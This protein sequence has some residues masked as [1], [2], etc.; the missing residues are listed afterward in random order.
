[1]NKKPITFK[2]DSSF[3]ELIKSA[4]KWEQAVIVFSEDNWSGYFSEKERSYR[5]YSSAK[6]FDEKT[7]GNSLY[8]DC[9]DNDD[10]GVRLDKY[11][12]EVGWIIE[13]CYVEVWKDDSGK[14]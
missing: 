1:M 6:Y 10:L 14:N 7:N 8:G 13:N 12:H 3:E 2:N 5:I 11:I 9:L 4:S